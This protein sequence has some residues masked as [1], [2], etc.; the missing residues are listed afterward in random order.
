[1]IYSHSINLKRVNLEPRPDRT[2]TIFLNP[3]LLCIGRAG[4]AADG[5]VYKVVMVGSGGVGKSAL[6]LRFMY[7]EVTKGRGREPL[8]S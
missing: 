3:T 7:D 5:P 1:M 6:T 4:M 8:S 2:Q